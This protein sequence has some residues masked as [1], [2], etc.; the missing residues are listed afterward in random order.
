M[1]SNFIIS[2]ALAS[3]NQNQLSVHSPGVTILY[4]PRN[5]AINS[6]F[7]LTM[8]LCTSYNP[9]NKHRIFTYTTLT[10]CFLMEVH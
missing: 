5:T 3:Q 4:M 10:D 6:E 2:L 9:H 8:D 1:F 7:F